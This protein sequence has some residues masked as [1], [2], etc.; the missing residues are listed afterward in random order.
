MIRLF[1]LEDY[2]SAYALWQSMPEMGLRHLD[3]SQTGIGRFLARNRK[4]C[5]IAENDGNVVG[6]ILSGHDGRRGY[7]YHVCVAPAFRKRRYG[8]R[9]VDAALAALKEEGIH[10]VALVVYAHNE[11]GIAFWERLGWTRR[12]D[13]VYY[14]KALINQNS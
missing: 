7:F 10:K 12:N 9:L 14:D 6:T 1:T 2:P 3:D 8:E 13:L 11:T 5:F 4:T